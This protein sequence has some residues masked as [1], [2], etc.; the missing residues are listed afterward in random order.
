MNEQ[1]VV[2]KRL[3][4]VYDVIS[5]LTVLLFTPLVIENAEGYVLI[6]VYLYIYL[7]ACYS[8]KSKS[9][10]PNRMKFGG[11]IGNYPG[12]ICFDFGIDRV[13]G[14]GHEKV[15]IFFESHEI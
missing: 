11:M 14:Q 7:Y 4:V 5:V 10:K 12:T 6:A 2:Y 1:H 9:I 13:K 8:H 3:W 15:K